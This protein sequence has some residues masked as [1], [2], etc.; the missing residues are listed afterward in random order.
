[1]K[2]PA[3]T[4]NKI[5]KDKNGQ[6]VLYFEITEEVLVHCNFVNDDYQRDWRVL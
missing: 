2:L 6:N 4:E 1:M 3:R 5:S